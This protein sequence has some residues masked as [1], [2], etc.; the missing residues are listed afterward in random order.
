MELKQF[1]IDKL[2]EY[3]KISTGSIEANDSIPTT[4]CQFDLAYLLQKQLVDLG[5]EDVHVDD[6]CFV[7]AYLNKQNT[8]SRVVLLAHM[9]T[10]EA[11]LNVDVKPIVHNFNGGDIILPNTTI[12]KQD[13]FDIKPGQ[14][15]I[16]SDGSTL[17][18][19][20]DKAGIAIIMTLLK[21]LKESKIADLPS[22]CICFT[23]DEETGKG[24]SSVSMEKLT[25]GIQNS[26]GITVDGCRRH[27]I[28]NETF[29]AFKFKI[30]VKGF[31]IH[32][33]EAYHKMCN[34]LMY[35][36][37][38]CGKINQKFTPPWESQKRDDYVYITDM[39]G[40][41]N[42]TVI[43]GIVRSFGDTLS[44]TKQ[45]EQ[46]VKQFEGEQQTYSDLFKINFNYQ[47][48]YPNMKEKIPE[49]LIEKLGKLGQKFNAKWT[50]IRGGTDGSRLTL[51]GLP[52][53]N[54]W[55]GSEKIH[56]IQEY[57][58]VEEALEAVQYLLDILQNETSM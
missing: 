58:V 22:I 42:F 46:F 4:K 8:K 28:E 5:L 35:A 20:D 33:G 56:S 52:T 40:D 49:E 38:L 7:Y 54:I 34:S 41:T 48:Q 9:D 13:L 19:A 17:L 57:N 51:N 31:N 26:F 55:T 25:S 12:S 27:E 23:P 18:G 21:L 53:P 36:A 50:P 39:K 29:N 11:A 43:E 45:L 47:F 2:V 16:T 3:C 32:P 6:K 30:E 14:T 44:L 37:D 10:T 15:V 24:V 1:Y